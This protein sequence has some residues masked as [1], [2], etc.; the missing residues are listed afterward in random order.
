MANISE[1]D[2]VSPIGFLSNLVTDAHTSKKGV[3]CLSDL[4]EK[5]VEQLRE[6]DAQTAVSQQAK[7]IKQLTP[8]ENAAFR[9][10]VRKEIFEKFKE[11]CKKLGKNES[12]EHAELLKTVGKTINS[13]KGLWLSQTEKVEFRSAYRHLE[14]QKAR[15]WQGIKQ[16][17]SRFFALSKSLD[18]E[19]DHEKLILDWKI[20]VEKYVEEWKLQLD[21]KK[22]A[23]FDFNKFE[24]RWKQFHDQLLAIGPYEPAAGRAQKQ[25]NKLYYS[26]VDQ[27][28]RLMIRAS[29]LQVKKL[30]SA[31]SSV[32]KKVD[33]YVRG[34]L[35]LIAKEL[36]KK[37][38]FTKK[39]E[40]FDP[41][42]L[43]FHK[44]RLKFRSSLQSGQGYVE[45]HR[46]I[47]R[48]A[49]KK[50][51]SRAVLTQKAAAFVCDR[52]AYAK[53]IVSQD[54]PNIRKMIRLQLFQNELKQ[55]EKVKDIPFMA[56]MRPVMRVD[57]DG[58]PVE[59]QGRGR[60]PLASKGDL[61]SQARRLS[62]AEKQRCALQMAVGFAGLHEK[63]LVHLDIKL[64]NILLFINRDGKLE[65]GI[66][67][68]G[69]MRG[70]GQMEF[71]IGT[72]LWM[73]PEMFNALGERS[74]IS[75]QKSMDIYSLGLSLVELFYPKI[76]QKIIMSDAS[77][78][79]VDQ[80]FA[81]IEKVFPQ[82]EQQKALRSLLKKMLAQKAED[83]PTAE[84]VKEELEKIFGSQERL[85]VE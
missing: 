21:K 71:P 48:G 78:I 18:V 61:A 19:G 17:F 8:Q 77:R 5:R 14:T 38:K 72:R 46:F 43:V 56:T 26:T 25:Y 39:F 62:F 41:D 54:Y 68:F 33:S 9:K 65:I 73:A 70:H 29:S 66:I 11:A 52:F 22:E 50:V 49:A 51:Y 31:Q 4:V 64:K 59:K 16:F 60:M 42:N 15:F 81:R 82:D 69:S 2:G 24:K 32:V 63:N 40:I 76:F 57:Q 12:K 80:L 3:L 1:Q 23:E 30:L 37:G 74:A 85:A 36:R 34:H 35:S 45:A 58:N 79:D 83:R 53:L 10:Q 75:V 84:K 20:D 6:D 44:F 13:W 7:K 67:D 28:N 27:M 47:G 55:N